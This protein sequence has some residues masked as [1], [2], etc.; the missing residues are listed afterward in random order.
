MSFLLAS[1]FILA[2]GEPAP[3]PPIA[4]AE[5]IGYLKPVE[6]AEW[7]NAVRLN[8][9]GE[10]RRGQG[11]SIMKTSLAASAASR[12]AQNGLLAETPEQIRARAQK[13]ID[14]GNLQ[15][16][17][18]APSLAR[19]RAVAAARA[20]EK[21]KPVQLVLRP[22]S[23]SVADGV[24]QCVARLRHQSAQLGF[25]QVH[26]IGAISLSAAGSLDRQAALGAQVRA[27]WAKADDRSLASPPPE[28][29]ALVPAAAPGAAPALSPGLSAASAP[30]QVA[31]VW[32]E[33]YGLTADGSQGL[34]FLRLADAHSFR[35]LASEAAFTDLRA[36]AAPVAACEIVFRDERSFVPRLTESGDWLF[37]FAA[38]SHPLASA[39]LAHLCVTQT[40][41]SVAAAPYV[42]IVAGGGPASA[43]GFGAKW[44]AT[45]RTG[46]PGEVAFEVAAIPTNG[47]PAEVGRLVVRVG[48]PAAK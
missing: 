24:V 10:K 31:V 29:Y 33:L 37:G 30:R 19:L 23:V 3:P 32:A 1:L 4:D 9:E 43:E 28:G 41:V 14:Q 35:I 17:Q 5:V 21:T 47:K 34:L 12:V 38:G 48:L 25:A 46:E 26:I 22:P 40:G 15:I 45:P 16:R 44:R 7:H 11:E 18:V 13:I 36:G 8:A 2:A 42:Q 39:V 27:V 6:A 20:A